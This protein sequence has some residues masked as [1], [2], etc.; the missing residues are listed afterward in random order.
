MKPHEY[1]Q[2]LDYQ[3]HNLCRQEHLATLGLPLAGKTVLEVGAGIGDHTGFLLDR[4]CRVTCTDGRDGLLEHLRSRH[5]NAVVRAWDVETAPP[6]ELSPHQVVYAYGLLYHT[7]DPESVL[8]HLSEL[9]EEFL[10]LETCVSFGE[11][12]TVNLVR[13]YCEDP[14]QALGGTGCR[15]TRPWVFAA[16]KRHFSFVYVT[17]LQPRHEEFPV[18]WRHPE[19]HAAAL[20]RAV[21]VAS[22]D[23]MSDELLSPRLLDVQSPVSALLGA[24]SSQSGAR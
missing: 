8:R 2:H 1:F 6:P 19:R 24:G 22:H 9:C 18:D 13:E 4:G 15:P 17:R 16:L 10:V 20:A 21:F 5:R 23:P 3:R 11:D 14:T 12:K 7:R